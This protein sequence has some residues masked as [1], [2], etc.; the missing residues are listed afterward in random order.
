MAD[1]PAI[2]LIEAITQ[3]LAYEMREDETVVVLELPGQGLGDRLDQRDGGHQ[4]FS[5]FM[6][7]SRWA[8]TSA[9]VSP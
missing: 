7:S 1:A 6:A 3:A 4:C 2:T 5:H 8:A 9:G